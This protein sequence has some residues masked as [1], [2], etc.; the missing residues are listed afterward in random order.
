[1]NRRSF[2]SRFLAFLGIG[3]FGSSVIQAKAAEMPNR[4]G[5]YW[6]KEVFFLGYPTVIKEV[7]TDSGKVVGYKLI[8]NGIPVG[9]V[10]INDN[11]L[12]FDYCPAMAKV[13]S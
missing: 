12:S 6:G 11:R 1:M 5:V 2:V 8:Q 3:F 7:I 9:D 4:E 13:K 10:S